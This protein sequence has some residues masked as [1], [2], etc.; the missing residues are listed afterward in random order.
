MI[1]V[2]TRG[3]DVFARRTFKLQVVKV[4]VLYYLDTSLF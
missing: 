3:L 4:D 2:S 1:P